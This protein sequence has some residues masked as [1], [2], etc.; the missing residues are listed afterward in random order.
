MKPPKRL[1]QYIRDYKKIIRRNKKLF[2]LAI[3][4]MCSP[5]E[6]QEM[7]LTRAVI[8]HTASKDVS[9][10]TI[11]RWH[12]ERG[13][14][15]IGYHYVIRKDGTVYKGRLLTK[16]GAHAKSR[17][18]YIGIALT[19]HDYFTRAQVSSLK[20]LLIEL[21]IKEIERHHEECPGKG[22]DMDRVREALIY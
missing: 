11:D 13:W 10:E 9:V 1:K 19:G 17:N 12:K 20:N 14:D 21:E 3:L 16:F 7:D 15:G 2:A 4:F 8:H 5:V 18:H 6:A 22:L